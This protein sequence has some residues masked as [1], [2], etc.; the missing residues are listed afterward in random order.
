MNSTDWPMVTIIVPVYNTQQYLRR[1]VESI[2]NQTYRNLEIILVDDGS[3]D[4]SGRICDDYAKKDSRI[5]VIHQTNGGISAARNA[6]LDAMSI[7][8]DG[9]VGFIDSDDYVALNMIEKMISAITETEADLCMCRGESV[10]ENEHHI[11]YSPSIGCAEIVCSGDEMLKRMVEEH[12]SKYVV[13]WNKLIK[14]KI[15]ANLRYK[16]NMQHED[17]YIIHHIFSMCHRVVMI[18]DVLYQYRVRSGSIMHCEITIKRFD[19]VDALLDRVSL[20]LSVN[21]IKL[22]ALTLI[23]ALDMMTNLTC[24]MDTSKELKNKVF[25]YRKQMKHFYSLVSLDD[26][27]F[28][29]RIKLYFMIYAWPACKMIRRFR[30]SR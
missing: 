12:L 24:Q 19:I 5:R 16:E 8:N 10:D 4:S 3:Q 22:A 29:Q 6:G 7:D 23:Q 26:I 15:F 11:K 9:Y 21:E 20:L 27:S 13:V 30:I 18:D 14:K 17:E 25:A 28:V 2:C 1:C